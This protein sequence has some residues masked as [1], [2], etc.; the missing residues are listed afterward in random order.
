MSTVITYELTQHKRLIRAGFEGCQAA[1]IVEGG[2]CVHDLLEL[3][4]RGCDHDVAMR[5]LAP[6]DGYP[7]V[8]VPD[9]L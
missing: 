4:I 1:Q 6:D 8:A 9:S 7:V 5:I 2:V 3:V